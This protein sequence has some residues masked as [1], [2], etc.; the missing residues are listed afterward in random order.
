MV[1][2]LNSVFGALVMPMLALAL[3]LLNGRKEWI[4]E[5]FRNRWGATTALVAVLVFFAWVGLPKLIK[6]F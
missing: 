4:G 2:K 6:I 3:L 1:Q 5:S